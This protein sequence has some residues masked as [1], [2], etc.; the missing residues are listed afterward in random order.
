[1]FKKARLL[2]KESDK[3]LTISPLK[4]YKH[5]RGIS[6]MP[7]SINEV[8]ESSKNYPIFFL[9]EKDDSLVPFVVLGLKEGENTFVNNSGE[10]R[11]G[12]YIPALFRAYPFVLSENE[13]NFS[14][15]FDDAYEGINQKDGSRIFKDDGALTEFGDSVVKFLEGLYSNLEGTKGVTKIIKELDILKTIDA[16]VEK[17]G[18]KFVLSGLLQVDTEKLNA[19]SDENLLKLVKS[20]GLNLIYAHLT[21]LTNFS[22]LA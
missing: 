15:A 20:G 7:V 10:W 3:N 6:Y 13:G 19:L 21:S 16:T 5:A 9:K 17:N 11:K 14:I 4:N 22:N 8:A 12:R 2:N 18:E 1:M